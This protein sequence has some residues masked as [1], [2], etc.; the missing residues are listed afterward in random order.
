MRQ[1]AHYIADGEPVFGKP[2]GIDRDA[3]LL[4]APT[5]DA[6]A[7]HPRDCRQKRTQLITGDV[8]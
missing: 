4:G 3:I 1:S 7:R 6:H 5:Q 2:R 8:A